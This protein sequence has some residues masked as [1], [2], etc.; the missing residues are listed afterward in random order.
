MTKPTKKSGSKTVSLGMSQ[1]DH[2][3]LERQL[4]ASMNVAKDKLLIA[5]DK[6]DSTQQN[7]IDDMA[8]K[9]TGMVKKKWWLSWLT[10]FY[11]IQRMR[12]LW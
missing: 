11:L 3:E 1:E 9:E 7:I 5:L 10:K 8:A 4:I 6:H 12:A 2:W